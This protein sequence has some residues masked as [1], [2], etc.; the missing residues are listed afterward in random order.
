M[1]L[2]IKMLQKRSLIRSGR[3]NTK[4]L[5]KAQKVNLKKE[6]KSLKIIRRED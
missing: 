3:V 6:I 1:E 2:T 5:K 4:L